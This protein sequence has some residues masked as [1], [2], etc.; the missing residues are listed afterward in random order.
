MC[1]LPLL[2]LGLHLRLEGLGRAS[3]VVNLRSRSRGLLL[4]LQLWRELMGRWYRL[5]DLLGRWNGLEGRLLVLM[6]LDGRRSQLLH[7]R[8]CWYLLL[9]LPYGR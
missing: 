6:A 9:L 4:N 2:E 3:L 8:L 7:C 1:M 5:L